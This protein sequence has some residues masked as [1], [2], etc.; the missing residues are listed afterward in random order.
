LHGE[1]KYC[2]QLIKLQLKSNEEKHRIS[3]KN[4]FKYF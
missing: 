4:Y 1:Q 3:K 2:Q